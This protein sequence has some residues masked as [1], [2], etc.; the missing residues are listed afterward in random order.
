MVVMF[1]KVT[2]NVELASMKPL[3][4]Q[5]PLVTTLSS[6]N[7]HTVLFHVCFHLKTSNLIIYCWY[8]NIKLTANST[9]THT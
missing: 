6:T 4:L 5:I 1:Y 9:I 8:I 7:Q 3:F 2:M